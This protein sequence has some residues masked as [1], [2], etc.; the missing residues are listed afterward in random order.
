MKACLELTEFP[1]HNFC[2]KVVRS[3]GAVDPATRTLLTEVD[4]P[5]PSNLLLEGEYAQVHFDAKLSGQRLSVPNN[6]LLFRPGGTV[7]AVVDSNNRIDLRKLAI[8][9]DL[10][11]SVEVLG[12]ISTSDAFVINPPDALEQGDRVRLTEGNTAS[13]AQ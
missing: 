5:N 7:V 3:A 4:V 13:A 8:G 12:G 1:G 2:G 11:T 10:G 9:N 6:A